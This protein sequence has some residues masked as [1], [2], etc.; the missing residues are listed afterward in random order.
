M[1]LVKFQRCANKLERLEI[2]ANLPCSEVWVSYSQNQEFETKASER[3]YCY[4]NGRNTSIAI[5]IASNVE[6]VT[7]YIFLLYTQNGR[8]F[9][10]KSK[11]KQTDDIH[12]RIYKSSIWQ[13]KFN[14]PVKFKS[15]YLKDWSRL[16]LNF[17][18]HPFCQ[19]CIL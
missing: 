16:F 1:R 7:S 19:C 6:E 9:H 8:K 10:R 5:R 2:D 11:Q 15:K 13:K 12:V 3:A 18:L 4:K 14:K 17:K